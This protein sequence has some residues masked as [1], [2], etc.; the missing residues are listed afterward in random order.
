MKGWKT[1]ASAVGAFCTGVT[2]IADGLTSDPIDANK[3]YQGI[4][5]CVGALGIVGIGHKIDKS[6]G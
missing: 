3:I 6:S 1:W 2:M 4:M 5:M